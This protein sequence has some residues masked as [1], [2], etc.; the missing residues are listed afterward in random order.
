MGFYH[1]LNPIQCCSGLF[2]YWQQQK[3][4]SFL[5]SINNLQELQALQATTS[6]VNI[7]IISELLSCPGRE[8]VA[9]KVHVIIW[10]Q[11]KTRIKS[12]CDEKYNYL[13]L[14]LKLKY[15]VDY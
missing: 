4:F 6:H 10:Q 15:L 9:C 12:K 3:D 13:I 11:N 1:S 8:A 7:F 2:Y 14:T 5:K